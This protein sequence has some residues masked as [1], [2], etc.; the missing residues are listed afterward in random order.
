MLTNYLH[1]GQRDTK[2]VELLPVHII[3]TAPFI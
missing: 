1:G 2:L 3:I